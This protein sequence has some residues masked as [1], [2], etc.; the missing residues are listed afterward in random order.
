M[1]NRNLGQ[2]LN[3][4]I[5]KNMPL[6]EKVIM[7]HL[8]VINGQCKFCWNPK[9]LDCCQMRQNE[10]SAQ[11]RAAMEKHRRKYSKDDSDDDA[12]IESYRKE[13][14]ALLDYIKQ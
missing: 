12:F 8:A 10:L 4:Q 9:T 7:T 11:A 13:L 14:Q 2:T 5:L 1:G 3:V 6:S